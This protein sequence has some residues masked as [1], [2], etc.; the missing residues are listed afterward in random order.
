M[1]PT[2]NH[3]P[4]TDALL[5]MLQS[6]SRHAE[7]GEWQDT[8]E[9]CRQ[10]LTRDEEN[11]FALYLAG[12]A[13]VQLKDPNSAIEYLSASVR[14]PEADT[15]KLSI[16][17]SL[18]LEDGR[19]DAA[20]PYL[21]R[22]TSLSPTPESLNRLA[23]AYA[24]LN[25]I[26]DAIIQFRRSLE[27]QSEN[28]IA[29]A[30]LY[31]LLRVTCEWGEELEILSK[32][33]DRLNSAALNDGRPTPEPPFDNIHRV[34]E[35]AQNLGVAR[36]WSLQISEAANEG[37]VYPIRPSRN[38]NAKIRV[39]YLSADFHD[40]ATAHLMRGVFQAHNRENFSIHAYSHGPD[41]GSAYRDSIR[42]SCDR[43]V[44]ISTFNDRKAANL[45]NRDGVDILVDLK[46][47]TRHNRLGIC[48]RRPAPLQATY[49]G[50]PG[51]S[52]AEFF[53]YILTDKVV[54]PPETL[55][56][57]SESAVFLPNSYQCNDNT[58][59]Y[60][61]KNTN[62]Y[63]D[64]RNNFSFIFCS[65]NNPIKIEKGFFEIWMN[66]L[67]SVPNSALWILQNNLRAKDNLSHAAYRA[68]V[69]PD[70]IVF[71]EMLPR[72]RH[73]E[74]MSCADLALD[75]QFYNGH[76][77]TS[78]ALWAGLPVLTMEGRHFASR[79]SSS[80]LLAMNLPELITASPAEYAAR[81]QHLATCPG[82]LTDIRHKIA[83][84][85]L[86][87]ALFDTGQF[88]LD[89][90]R[91]YREIWRRFVAGKPPEVINVADLPL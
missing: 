27:I 2:E 74:R 11:V 65:F 29:S 23:A 57:L 46:G 73:L 51:T 89:L 7:L 43:F 25:Q 49:L 36:S 90:E 34:N 80:L 35:R 8:L 52:G 40:H 33:I 16:L 81:A 32:Q 20:I 83:E 31:P 22:W 38:T 26:G 18:L 21:E 10:V 88:T 62:N 15:S 17:A 85:R 41:D 13:S 68:G 3:D 39:G 50:F 60:I 71:A 53:D 76:T 55:E 69:E 91:A 4:A 75:T 66:L 59:D 6:A 44:D 14:D 1:S 84:S 24:D 56:C 30:G 5:A 70:H 79:V 63:S 61:N 9:L 77:T 82:E 45:I 12:I 48:A 28:N 67:K 47:H 87:S 78:D 64:I 86:S 58:Q 37:D 72:A 19:T 42:A 54:T